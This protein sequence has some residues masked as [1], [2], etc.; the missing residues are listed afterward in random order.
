MAIGWRVLITCCTNGSFTSK[1]VAFVWL[2]TGLLVLHP[3]YREQGQ[4]ALGR[5]GLPDWFMY[6]TCAAEVLLGLR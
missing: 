1:S 4:E 2:A 6:A 5:L 3:Y